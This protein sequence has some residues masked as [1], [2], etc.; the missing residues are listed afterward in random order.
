VARAVGLERYD[1]LGLSWGGLLAQQVALTAPRRVRRVVL[2][3]T[4]FGLG[5]V[6]GRLD[7]L[8]V[9]ATPA[10]YHSPGALARARSAFGGEPGEVAVEHHA[11]RLARPPACGAMSTRS[12]R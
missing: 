4:N 12:W 3:I 11:A 10:R 9:P 6:P 8:R 1:L 2:A 5:S 7:A